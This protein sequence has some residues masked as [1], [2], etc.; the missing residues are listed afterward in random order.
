MPLLVPFLALAACSSQSGEE[1][2]LEQPNNAVNLSINTRVTRAITDAQGITSFAEGDQIT[3]YSSG[4]YQE[5]SAEPFVVK[6]SGELQHTAAK[7]FSYYGTQG[8]TFYAYYPSNTV[9]TNR[10][11]ATFAVSSDQSMDGSF[12]FSDLMTA[13]S[14]VNAAQSEAVNLSFAHRLALVKVDLTQFDFTVKNVELTNVYS[15]ATWSYAS[16]T[17]TTVTTALPTSVRMG[18]NLAADASGKIYWAVIPA[19]TMMKDNALIMITTDTGQSYTYSPSNDIPFN[20]GTITSFALKLTG[21]G[22]L[23]NISTTLQSQWGSTTNNE[24]CVLEEFVYVPAVTSE[25]VIMPL[26]SNCSE[27]V[28]GRWGTLFS[29]T[30]F[31]AVVT[32]ISRGFDFTVQ[33]QATTGGSWHNRTLYYRGS[34]NLSLNDKYKLT[35]SLSSVESGQLWLSVSDGSQFYHLNSST[36][37]SNNKGSRVMCNSSATAR[38]VE[39]IVN[40]TVMSTSSTASDDASFLPN[41]SIKNFYI[42]LCASSS[43][44]TTY[45]IKDITLVPYYE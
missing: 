14:K 15:Q 9:S 42:G 31:E 39:V 11:E 4:L 8:A 22:E 17:V 26:T 18:T 35:F 32:P 20:E 38:T 16:N 10:Y 33:S 29:A 13:T 45:T 23:V 19:Q 30:G 6:A 27:L 44:L 25:T 36:Y 37:T 2:V 5:M 7:T 12:G 41:S 43:T 1:P 28:E 24:D 3:L 40:P 21:A 34:T